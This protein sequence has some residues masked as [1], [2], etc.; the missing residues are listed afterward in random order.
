MFAESLN[1]S[2]VD[3]N[4]ETVISVS[5]GS[6]E[7]VLDFVDAF[8][9]T[10]SVSGTGANRYVFDAQMT[11]NGDLISSPDPAVEGTLDETKG[12]LLIFIL[13]NGN[14]TN[15]S[16]IEQIRALNPA[17]RK[18]LLSELWRNRTNRDVFS[19]IHTGR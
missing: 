8:Q 19:I 1:W 16:I 17:G 3:E 10:L 12:G 15:G 11:V 5:G 13:T 18:D 7:T 9:A 2:I 14:Y 4:D 6:Y